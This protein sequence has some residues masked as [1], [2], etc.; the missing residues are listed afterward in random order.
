M[1]KDPYGKNIS[2]ALLIPKSPLSPMK[3]HAGIPP[4]SWGESALMETNA[5]RQYSNTT[6]VREMKIA[7][8]IFLLGFFTSSPV[9]T[10]IS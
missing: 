4:V 8:G 9:C 10:I 6:S 3:I 1:I 7:L 2:A 5:T